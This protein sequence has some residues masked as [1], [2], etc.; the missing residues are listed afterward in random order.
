[1]SLPYDAPPRTPAE[2]LRLIVRNLNDTP[3]DFNDRFTLEQLIAI[4]RAHLA[5]EWDIPPERWTQSQ[6]VDALT[7]GRAPE[8]HD[9][10]TPL[11]RFARMPRTILDVAVDAHNEGVRQVKRVSRETKKRKST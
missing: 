4:G 6:L 11:R 8:W 9:D 7:D 2:T 10:G 1:M 5:S 3:E